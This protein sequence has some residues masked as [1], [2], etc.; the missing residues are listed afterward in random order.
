MI[1]SGA[2][3]FYCAKGKRLFIFIYIFIYL[4]IGD[5][6]SHCV[7]REEWT[8]TMEWGEGIEDNVLYGEKL[9]VSNEIC[10]CTHCTTLGE[11]T[12][13]VLAA[14][15]EFVECTMAA[16]VTNLRRSAA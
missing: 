4:F 11:R 2:D 8:F 15:P 12:C 13:H 7:K 6:G 14:V 5:L 1:S 3:H 16:K 10:V 9:S